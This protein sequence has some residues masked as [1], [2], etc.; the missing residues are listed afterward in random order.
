MAGRTQTLTKRDQRNQH[1]A[2]KDLPDHIKADYARIDALVSL[3][4]IPG[5]KPWTDDVERAAVWHAAH[6]APPIM[7]LCASGMALRTAHT[8]LSDEPPE[9]YKSACL[10]LAARLKSAEMACAGSVFGRIYRAS[11]DP[12]NWTAGAWLMER[13]HGFV[14]AKDTEHGPNI[15]VNIGSV[16]VTGDKGKDPIRE[17]VDAEVIQAQ[18]PASTGDPDLQS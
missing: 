5:P 4:P 14:A 2:P 16:T 9:T 6:A 7:A 11:E 17:I 15:V 18:I 8:Y 12:R 3:P 10:A 1:S 13:K